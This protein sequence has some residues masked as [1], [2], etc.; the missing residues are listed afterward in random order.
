M[1]S[2]HVCNEERVFISIKPYEDYL[3]GLAR[4]VGECLNL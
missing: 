2:L 1:I 3:I 4:P